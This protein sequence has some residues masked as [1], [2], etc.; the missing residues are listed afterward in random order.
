MDA[1]SRT[2]RDRGAVLPIVLVIAVV[3]A[4]VAVAIASYTAT[5]LKS[6]QV[7]EARVDRLADAE[8]G[9]QR[10]LDSLAADGCSAS[11]GLGENGS[12]L[13][14][15]GCTVETVQVGGD[16]PYSLM[17]TAEGVT[18][19]LAFH[20]DGP[21]NEEIEIN[22]QVYL[23]QNVTGSA[24]PTK[25]LA[26]GLVVVQA[27]TCA[28]A[29][30]SPSWLG[31]TNVDCTTDDWDTF[32]SVPS[33]GPAPGFNAPSAPGCRVEK[34]PTGPRTITGSVKAND[35]YFA[36]GIYR[37]TGELVLDGYVV[38]GHPGAVTLDTSDPCYP[39]QQAD[40]ANAAGGGPQGVVFV[41]EGSGRIVID[42]NDTVALFYGLDIGSDRR[43]SFVGYTSSHP[44]PTGPYQ[45]STRNPNV[46]G[47]QPSKREG[48]FITDHPNQSFAFYGEVWT[49]RGF[50]DVD[51]MSSNGDAGAAFQGGAVIARF[52]AKT[53]NDVS[54]II[55]SG[56]DVPVVDYHRLRVTATADGVSTTVS[57]VAD[58]D[59]DGSISVKSWRVL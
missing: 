58:L 19:P 34:A 43:V 38:A 2:R 33:I 5:A 53:S 27:A 16:V 7:T 47:N 56:D 37:V 24:D 41:V 22:G 1:R 55:F 51:T 30:S 9:M 59:P 45:P 8:L 6:T 10:V 15:S 29:V 20:R 28:T 3:F 57:V 50:I 17:L 14:L 13:T 32:T 44:A 48:I 49:P 23:A 18:T 21:Q 35:A 39:V 25:L 4:V 26:P 46:D 54:G 40:V 36:S 42:G 12:T 31:A 11:P 52:K